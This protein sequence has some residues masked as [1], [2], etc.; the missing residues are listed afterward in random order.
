MLDCTELSIHQNYI[1]TFPYYLFGAVFQSYLKC[2]LPGYSPH[3]VPSKSYLTTLILCMFFSWHGGTFESK[4]HIMKNCTENISTHSMVCAV[5]SHFSHV[6]LL[7]APWTV[8]CQVSM[9]MGLSKQEYWSG[10]PFSSSK[11]SSIPR[12]WTC[13]S[14][15]S[16]IGKQVLYH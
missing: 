16:C 2:Y 12:V 9:S 10:L 11:G 14:L 8:A 7:A 5:L 3:F 6:W 13:A 4:G 15:V 1:L